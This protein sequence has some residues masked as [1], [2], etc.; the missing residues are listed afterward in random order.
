MQMLRTLPH[1]GLIPL[2]IVWMGI[3]EAPK[4]AL[5]I[6]GKEVATHEVKST[7]A[8]RTWTHVGLADTRF[9]GRRLARREHDAEAGGEDRDQRHHE[10]RQIRPPDVGAWFTLGTVSRRVT[11]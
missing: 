11:G 9:I 8:G 5:L 6:D 3:G 2:F 10:Q 7:D 1:F 4:I